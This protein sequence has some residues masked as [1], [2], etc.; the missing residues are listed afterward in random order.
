MG[1]KKAAALSIFCGAW[2]ILLG[3]L[4]LY[5]FI[6]GYFDIGSQYE[7]LPALYG[8]I[9]TSFSILGYLF[10]ILLLIASIYFVGGGLLL[11]RDKTIVRNSLKGIYIMYVYYGCLNF[12]SIL[13]AGMTKNFVSPPFLMT[14]IGSILV[15]LPA[16]FLH[17]IL[18]A[19]YI[20]K[21]PKEGK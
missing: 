17:R 1:N 11:F 20:N 7:K 12:L 5:F 21:L 8:Y 19:P 6:F 4:I 16:I 2:E 14:T 3:G 9:A 18:K 13:L 10:T 15:V